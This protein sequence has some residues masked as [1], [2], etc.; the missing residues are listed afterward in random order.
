MIKSI[1]YTWFIVLTAETR[2]YLVTY[3]FTVFLIGLYFDTRKPLQ[4]T[5][6]AM[7]VSG[8]LK[9]SSQLALLPKHIN[10]F[11]NKNK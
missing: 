1:P 2:W 7:N 6:S 4:L 11:P 3:T 9:E 10:F 8:F 5:T